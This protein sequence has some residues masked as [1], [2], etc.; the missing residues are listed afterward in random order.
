M[1]FLDE[2]MVEILFLVACC[3]GQLRVTRAS[4]INIKADFDAGFIAATFVYPP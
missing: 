3:C 2:Q 1:D 4:V